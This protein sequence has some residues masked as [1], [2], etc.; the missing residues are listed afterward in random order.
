VFLDKLKLAEEVNL[1][2]AQTISGLQALAASG[3]LTETRVQEI[4][5]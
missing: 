2:D 5:Q 3:L 4:L 1:T